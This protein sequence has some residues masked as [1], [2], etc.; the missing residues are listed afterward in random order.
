[1]GYQ[2]DIGSDRIYDNCADSYGFDVDSSL[3]ARLKLELAVKYIKKDM[4]VLDVGCANGLFMMPLADKCASITGIDINSKMLGIAQEKMYE[5]GIKNINL[6]R[7]SAMSMGFP[8]DHFDVAY[9]YSLLPLVPDPSMVIKEIT[10]VLKPGGLALLDVPGRY[11]LSRVFFSRIYRRHG[12][13]GIKS[14]ARM[15]ILTLLDECDL[16]VLEEHALGFAAQWRY[17]PG[18]HWCKFLE[19][20]FH[21]PGRR[22]LDYRIS[23]V[24]LLR[25]LANR[26]YLVCRK[27]GLA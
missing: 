2:E 24:D 13:P 11:N 20:V 12:H 6:V 4:R 1:M 16:D 19:K 25:P 26:W 5:H 10:R 27:G 14:F 8:D 3:P 18:L 23:N 7:Q 9:C 15:Q 17:V 21:K 22:D